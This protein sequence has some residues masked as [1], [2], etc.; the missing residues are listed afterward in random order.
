MVDYDRS[1]TMTQ[2]PSSPI[3]R[4]V[5]VTGCSSGI[6]RASAV[7]LAQQGFIVFASVRKDADADSLR[8]L[9]LP[10]LIPI[11]P[12]DLAQPE[13]IAAAVETIQAEIA[14]RGINGLYGIVNNA[15]G[16]GVAPIELMDLDKFRTELEARL[17]GPIALLQ[18][19]LPA[20]RTAHG[21]IIWIATPSTIPIPYVGSIHIC[22]F[23]ANCVARTLQIEL[24]RWQIP[25]V[26]V[27]C[28]GVNT[29]APAKSARELAK[30]PSAN[31]SRNASPST[32]TRSSR[33]K[34]NW[35]S[36]TLGAP[37][38]ARSRRSSTGR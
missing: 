5:L 15:G 22:D 12:L 16:G 14:A 37:I 18:A 24:K 17:V 8:G 13:S 23:A 29:S 25:N 35:A 26:L 7:M 33:S 19:L 21:R 32:P 36:S 10:T 9:N 34:K 30:H 28:G 3:T 1:K 4:A 38:R 31:G 20:I 27:R 2:P 11:C 6:G